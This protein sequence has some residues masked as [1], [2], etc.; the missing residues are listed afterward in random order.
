MSGCLTVCITS[1]LVWAVAVDFT[2]LRLLLL[3]GSLL[4]HSFM[5]WVLVI[6]ATED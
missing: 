2:Q 3:L 4:L 6:V 1:V 5:G